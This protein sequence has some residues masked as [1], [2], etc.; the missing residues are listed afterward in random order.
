MLIPS[1]M[2][3]GNQPEPRSRIGYRELVESQ[4]RDLFTLRSEALSSV[5][6]I[7]TE[8]PC[9]PS[10]VLF[11]AESKIKDRDITE[12]F[13]YRYAIRAVVLAALVIPSLEQC[14]DGFE[15]FDGGPADLVT[16]ECRMAALPR[17]ERCV[18][19]LRDVL[20]YTKRET[21]LLL[22]MAD[23]QVDDSLHRGRNRLLLQ[24][25]LAL[26]RVKHHFDASVPSA[27]EHTGHEAFLR[28]ARPA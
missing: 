19:F 17:A 15:L 1:V 23:S 26:E 20:G 13:R 4:W 22:G 11:N 21:G 10:V 8:G 14:P 27:H 28:Y 24:G 7:L 25:P 12:G 6:R 5:A 3:N 2:P 9:S 16:F 18:V